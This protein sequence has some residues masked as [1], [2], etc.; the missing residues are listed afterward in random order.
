MCRAIIQTL[1]TALEHYQMSRARNRRGEKIK[2]SAVGNG[3]GA[4]RGR[5]SGETDGSEEPC[6]ASPLE[7]ILSVCVVNLTIFENARRLETPGYSLQSSY[8]TSSRGTKSSKLFGV[9]SV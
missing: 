7:K 9:S 8:W 6:R 2:R 1:A 3:E 5:Q 4:E